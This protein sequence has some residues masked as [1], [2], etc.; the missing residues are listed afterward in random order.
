VS[1]F[2]IGEEVRKIVGYPFIGKV[3]SL[4]DNEDKVVVK[5]KDG[6]EHIFSEKQLAVN[7]PEYQYLDLLKDVV[8]NGVYREGRNGGTYGLFGRQIRFNLK[9]GFPLLT[10]K[11]I[12]VKSVFAE[13]L[14][15]LSGSTNN[16]DL[17]NQGVNIWNEWAKED[18]SLGPI[19]SHQWR[20]FGGQVDQ[21]IDVI[22]ALKTDPNSRRHV[23][24]AWN[25]VDLPE[26]ALPPCHCLFQFFVENGTLSCQLYQRSGDIFLGVPFNIASYALLVHLIARETNLQVGEFIHTFGDV[27]LYANHLGPAKEQLSRTPQIGFPSLY[28]K[29][30][31]GIFDITLNDFEVEGYI[32]QATIKALVSV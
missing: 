29:G 19:Y 26:M 16:N 7:Y 4:Y 27:H 30:T 13:L 23:V 15:F 12:H 8:E 32:P 10:T 1:N 2:Y 6:W 21:I 9:D 22:N 24:S 17:K 20:S 11:R 3:C 14:W 25:P 18:G 5:H 31:S 28:I